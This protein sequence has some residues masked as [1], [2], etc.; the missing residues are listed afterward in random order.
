M[1]SPRPACP[2]PCAGS[3]CPFTRADAECL[4]CEARPLLDAHHRALAA[5]ADGQG[6]AGRQN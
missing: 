5:W 6:I 3:C 1:T 2:Y 4:A